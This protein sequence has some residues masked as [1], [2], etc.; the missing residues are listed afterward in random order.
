MLEA[1]QEEA[2]GIE[3]FSSS[4]R[5]GAILRIARLLASTLKPSA[6]RSAQAPTKLA[7]HRR[8]RKQCFGRFGTKVMV[9]RMRISS[10]FVIL[11]KFGTL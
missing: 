2:L 1:N 4:P 8:H 3:V 10:V 6:S 7:H 9:G 11:P 5:T